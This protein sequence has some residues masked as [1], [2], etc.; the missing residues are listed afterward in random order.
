MKRTIIIIAAALTVA[1][2]ACKK[3]NPV[4]EVKNNFVGTWAGDLQYTGA[5]TRYKYSLDVNSDNTVINIDSAFNNQVFPGT[6]T[7][8]TDSLKIIYA[9]GT[10]WNLKLTSNTTCA[11]GVLGYSGAVGTTSMTKK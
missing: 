6:Y 5:S 1:I 10:K 9:N 11:G 8:T 7:F 2:A 4:T 3:S